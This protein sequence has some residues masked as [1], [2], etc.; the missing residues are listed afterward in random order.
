MSDPAHILASLTPT[1]DTSGLL[2]APQDSFPVVITLGE[3][4]FSAAI[5]SKL[6]SHLAIGSAVSV[7]LRFLAPHAALL[8]APLDSSFSFWC[9][10]ATKGIGKVV[11]VFGV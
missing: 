3:H 4:S 5:V 6:P 2:S 8:Q 9:P 1:E 7:E 10:P 11:A